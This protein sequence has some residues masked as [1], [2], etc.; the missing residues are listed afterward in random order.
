MSTPELE[1]ATKL[2]KM[3]NHNI[4][5]VKSSAMNMTLKR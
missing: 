3:A 2:L 4:I 5:E 1:Q